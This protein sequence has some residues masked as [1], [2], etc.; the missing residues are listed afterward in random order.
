MVPTEATSLIPNLSD[1]YGYDGTLPMEY[2]GNFT[3]Y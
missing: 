1:D 2:D 3:D